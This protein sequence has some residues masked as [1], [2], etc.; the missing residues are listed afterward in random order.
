MHPSVR[1]ACCPFAGDAATSVQ[2]RCDDVSVHQYVEE[3]IKT[4]RTTLADREDRRA[5]VRRHYQESH[6]GHDEPRSSICFSFSPRPTTMH[7][8]QLVL[9][10]F[11][12][13]SKTA[14]FRKVEEKVCFEQWVFF[15]LL[16]EDSQDETPGKTCCARVRV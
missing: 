2:V 7:R 13:R 14:W 5:Q 11:E 16:K 3:H 10:F 4:F 9:S 15:I 12:T 6:S 8:D 1:H